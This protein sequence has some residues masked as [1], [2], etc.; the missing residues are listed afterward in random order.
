MTPADIDG[1]STMGGNA[2]A[3][4]QLWASCRS[5][6]STRSTLLGPAFVEPAL[7]AIS[8]VASGTGAHLRGGPPDPPDGWRQRRP[9]ARDDTESGPMRVAGDHQFSRA[10]SVPGP[11]GATIGAFQ[12]QRHMQQY[13]TTYEQ[14]ATNAVTARY[15][16]SLHPE[17]IFRDP[18]TVED[19]LDAAVH[20]RAAP[21]PRLR[22]PGRL[23]RGGDLHH[24]R[25]RRR[26]AAEAGEGRGVRALGRSATST[27]R[28]ST[29]SPGT[30][31]AHC[32][33]TLWS[34][35]DLKPC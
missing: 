25:A 34:R 29:T 24:A 4:G 19:Y 3:M 13:G 11:P 23:G 33:E 27:C 35:T 28:C 1:I 20:L 22:L 21:T 15:H 17:A 14:F 2:M 7:M 18:I 10:R 30:R 8:A 12:M 5:T 32:A 31:P 9:G 16:A 26:L 6:T